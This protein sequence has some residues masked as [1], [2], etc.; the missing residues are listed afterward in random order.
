MKKL[1]AIIAAIAL[2]LAP[3]GAFADRSRSSHGRSDHGRS[4]SG[5]SHRDYNGARPGLYNGSGPSH[6]HWGSSHGHSGGTRLSFGFSSGGFFLGS[7]G[8]CAPRVEYHAPVIVAPRHI[9]VV[10]R[11]WTTETCG[12][13]CPPEY[14]GCDTYG[15]RLYS[16]GYTV[17]YVTTWSQKCCGEAYRCGTQTYRR[18]D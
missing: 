8:Y 4:W 13:Y 10:E 7:S 1:F 12:D 14:V 3:A 16:R 9:C 2:L 5:H 6:N 11:T 17:V 18:Y 15:R